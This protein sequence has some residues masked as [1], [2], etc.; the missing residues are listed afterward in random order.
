MGLIL[1]D[2]LL[3]LSHRET[4]KTSTGD[5]EI[6]AHQNKLSLRADALTSAARRL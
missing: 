4:V 3:T 1:A 6:D 2:L 5:V